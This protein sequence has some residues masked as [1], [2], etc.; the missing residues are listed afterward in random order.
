MLEIQSIA[1]ELADARG[2]NHHAM[3]ILECQNVQRSV[4]GIAKGLYASSV[5]Y[6]ISRH[7]SSKEKNELT[8]VSR[9]SGAEFHMI[10]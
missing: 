9:L 2:G 7:G 10:M 1:I 5:I 4:H 3:G 6:W 8:V